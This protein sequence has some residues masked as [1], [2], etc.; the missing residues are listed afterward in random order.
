MNDNM[1]ITKVEE[2][3]KEIVLE[4]GIDVYRMPERLVSTFLKK[5]GDEKTALQ[6]ELILEAG[7]FQRYLDQITS[8]LTVIDI[9]NLIAASSESG[10]T[11]PV[12]RELVSVMLKSVGISDTLLLSTDNQN[13]KENEKEQTLL[14]GN[15]Y[16]SPEAYREKLQQI[17]NCIYQ[18]KEL[19]EEKFSF[20]NFCCEAGIPQALY[21]LGR[22]Y[23]FGTGVERDLLKA[24]DY[25]L[26]AVELGDA[27]AIGFLGDCFFAKRNYSKA[28]EYYTRPGAIAADTCRRDR[29]RLLCKFKEYNKKEVIR[30][31]FAILISWLVMFFLLPES[32]ITGSHTFMKVLCGLLNLVVAGYLLYKVRKQPFYNAQRFGLLAVLVFFIYM[33]L[34]IV[35]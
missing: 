21:L 24:R 30:W 6:L 7:Y 28:F 3:L 16:I 29:I 33:L 14:V 9:N 23:C 5:N 31:I 13:N 27:N 34:Y 10:L 17:K 22:M 32:I 20:L 8:G 15:V 1:E 19:D 18:S 11:V 26:R 12:I 25:L 2:I 35:V 4:Q